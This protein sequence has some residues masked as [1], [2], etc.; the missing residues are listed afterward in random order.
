LRTYPETALGLL[1]M[2]PCDLSG[3]VEADVCSGGQ[4]AAYGSVQLCRVRRVR[5]LVH[6]AESTHAP[7]GR[8]SRSRACRSAPAESTA[9]LGVAAEERR[10]RGSTLRTKVISAGY[11]WHRRPSRRGLMISRPMARLACAGPSPAWLPSAA[12]RETCRGQTPWTTNFTPLSH[13][14]NHS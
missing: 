2:G 3:S 7:G 6:A 10:R 12:R 11:C 14:S 1:F 8:S 9:V 5:V 13:R 4:S